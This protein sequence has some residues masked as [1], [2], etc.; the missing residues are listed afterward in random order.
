[1]TA[2]Q[3]LSLLDQT[4]WIFC[5]FSRSCFESEEGIWELGYIRTYVIKPRQ[6]G[7]IV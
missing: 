5:L 6:T 2:L 4:Q 7:L 1:M 3:E